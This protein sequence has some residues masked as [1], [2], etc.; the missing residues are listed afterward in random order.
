MLI[1]EDTLPGL[2]Q[3]AI[4]E[5]APA[6]L[7]DVHKM[8][9]RYELVRT[10]DV[11][12]ALREANYFP[13]EVQQHNPS[14][15]DPMFV[16]HKVV[17]RSR[18]SIERPA[19]VGDQVSQIV[20]LN[21]H[22]GRKRLTML[23]GLY[24][25][26]CANGLI[27]GEDMMKFTARHTGT[28]KEDALTFTNGMIKELPRIND[29]IDRWGSIELSPSKQNEFAWRA[30]KLRWAK[31]AQYEA[32]VMLAPRRPTDV[33]NDLWRVFNRVQENCV[34]GGM[35]AIN[36]NGRRVKS[37]ALTQID[38]NAKFNSDLW[39]LAEEFALN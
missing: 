33:G 18:E 30:R 36:E 1:T 39:A 11:I 38:Y 25:F 19:Q 32:D 5:I 4:Q 22:N 3:K 14:Q 16:T 35:E 13:V 21:S 15:R 12:E 20:I 9:D 7:T 2:S 8:S 37:G 29:A 6:I 23:A 10:Y 31:D 34:K 24:R 28:I 27:I 17:L 26:V